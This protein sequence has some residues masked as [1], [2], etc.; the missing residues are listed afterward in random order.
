M[1]PGGGWNCGNPEV[2]GVAGEPLVI[3][4]T[5]ALLALRRHPERSENIESLAWMEK[6]FAHIKGPGSYALARICLS[7][8][9][10]KRNEDGPGAGDYHT[11]N[12]SLQ[13]VEVAAWMSL[14][15]RDTN[16]WLPGASVK[17]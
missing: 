13:S 9:G 5:W 12:E 7:A 10:C 14:A 3:P 17:S 6:N 11:K 15:A 1:C 2:Y 4:T 16:K 8:Y